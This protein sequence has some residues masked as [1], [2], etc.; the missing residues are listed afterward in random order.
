MGSTK[1]FPC[2]NNHCST[3]YEQRFRHNKHTYTIRKLLQKTLHGS[4]FYRRIN[5]LTN[6]ILAK[7]NISNFNKAL[8]K[9][10]WDQ[11]YYNNYQ[12]TFSNFQSVFSKCFMNNFNETTKFNIRIGYHTSQ[13]D[14]VNQSNINIYLDTF[15][16]KSN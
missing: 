13:V 14:Y 5:L 12:N 10:E 15:M 16:Q 8:N 11:I 6:V 9:Y 3:R 2:A 1:W 7:K 4:H